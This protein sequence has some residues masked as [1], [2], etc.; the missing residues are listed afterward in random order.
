[1]LEIA[2]LAISLVLISIASMFFFMRRGLRYMQFLQQEGY[3]ENRFLQWLLKHRAF[4]KRG[5]LVAST[6][7]I[8]TALF[9][10]SLPQMV[11]TS[12]IVSAVLFYRGLREENPRTSGKVLLKLTERANRIFNTAQSCYGLLLLVLSSLEFLLF[13]RYAVPASWLTQ[14]ILIQLQPLILVLAKRLLDPQE[15]AVQSNFANE[16]RSIIAR[17]NPITIG[18][19]GS[20]GKTST[21]VM[22][23][24]ILN[25]VAPTFSTPGSINSYMG[26]T[27]EIR[28][29][30][31]DFHRFAVIEIGAHYTGSIKRMCSLTPPSAAIITAVGEMHL[32][33]FGSLENLYKAKSELAQAVSA[34]GILVCNG[35]YEKCRQM[36]KENPKRI[37]LLYGLDQSK[38]NLDAYMYDIK[39][40]EKGSSFKIKFNDQVYDGFSK[41]L[42]KPL[43][44]NALAAFTMT[45]AL[46]CAP[47]VALA[48]IRN[49]KTEKNRLEPV[50]TT[51]GSLGNLSNGNQTKA[52]ASIL[53]LNDA[54]NSNPVGFAAA[55][56]VMSQLPTGRKILVTP[57]MIELADRQEQENKNVAKQAASICDMVIVVGE[58][59]RSSIIAGLKEGGMPESKYKTKSSMKEALQYLASD[60]CQEGDV[61]LIEND[62]PDVYESIP[63]F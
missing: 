20:Y 31:K 15:K 14:L 49:V 37:T 2:S 11:I 46:G 22:L 3:E 43:L 26:M 25:S 54:F 10:I 59:N 38:G 1:M 6:G 56:E 52:N 40:S 35:D 7:L 23:A 53:R 16:A 61:V 17:V 8:L 62:L 27:R 55:L 39:A 44:S 48:A 4:D 24:E 42:G 51:I 50:R 9:S 47:E 21:K 29:R 32:E 19:T 36:A 63:K 58:T 30:M 41:V 34:D 60:F 12:A 33:R 45:L 5:S 18:I 13:K 28:E 57:G